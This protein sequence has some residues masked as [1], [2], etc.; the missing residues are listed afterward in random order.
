MSRR[1]LEAAGAIPTA[2]SVLYSFR[3]YFLPV[4]RSSSTVDNRYTQQKNLPFDPLVHSQSNGIKMWA[5]KGEAQSR[6][7][8]C[9][10]HCTIDRIEYDN[11]T[12]D[13]TVLPETVIYYTVDNSGGRGRAAAAGLLARYARKCFWAGWLH[14]AG[15]QFARLAIASRQINVCGCATY[16]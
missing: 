6:W 2:S 14:N 4:V 5:G 1:G 3:I 12:V 9:R 8:F 16:V 11:T 13:S 10:F 7:S 15:R